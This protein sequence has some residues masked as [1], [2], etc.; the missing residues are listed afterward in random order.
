MTLRGGAHRHDIVEIIVKFI[1]VVVSFI[2]SLS[3]AI[4]KLTLSFAVASSFGD[5]A[6]VS[7]SQRCVS[8]GGS[9]GS[10]GAGLVL[11]GIQDQLNREGSEKKVR[12]RRFREK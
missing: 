12:R 11:V 8:E 6:A 9:I 3:G 1:I 5:S 7:G 2:S 10:G 4:F